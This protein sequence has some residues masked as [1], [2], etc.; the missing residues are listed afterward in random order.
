MGKDIGA[1][2]T[3]DEFTRVLDRRL[4]TQALGILEEADNK[5]SANSKIIDNIIASSI[6]ALENRLSIKIQSCNDELEAVAKLSMAALDMMKQ[7]IL[8]DASLLVNHEA[9]I[10]RLELDM[11]AYIQEQA[12]DQMNKFPD[13]DVELVRGHNKALND[14]QPRQTPDEDVEFFKRLYQKYP[15]SI[16][17]LVFGLILG[18]GVG[19]PFAF[20]GTWGSMLAVGWFLK[21]KIDGKDSDKSDPWSR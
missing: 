9:M 14:P 4:K 19:H 6:L 3:E 11:E 2:A 20:L 12:R 13:E 10:K 21:E 16:M 5:I 7:D 18:I 1:T 8:E 17:W 15:K